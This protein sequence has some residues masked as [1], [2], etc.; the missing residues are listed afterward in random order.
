MK[1]YKILIFIL[2]V[3]ALLGAGWVVFPEE[4][5]E[6]PGTTLRFASLSEAMT[7]LNEEKV[8]VDNVLS[9]LEQSFQLL[10]GSVQDS[11]NFYKTYMESN[12]NRIWLPEGDYSYFDNIFSLLENA[13][14]IGKTYRIMHYGDSQIEMDHITG[15]FRE[16][17]QNLFGGSGPGMIPAQQNVPGVS[18]LQYA[19]GNIN[20]YAIYADSTSFRSSHNRYGVMCYYSKCSGSAYITFRPTKHS[21]SQ[22]GVKNFHKVNVLIGN[23]SAGFSATLKCDGFEAQKKTCEEAVEGMTMLSWEFPDNIKKGTLSFTGTAEIYAITL[24]GD[25]GVAVDNDGMRGCGGTIFSMINSEQ[26]R[27]SYQMLDTKLIMLQFGGNAMP[28]IYNDKGISTYL[29]KIEKQLDYFAK[30]APQAKLLFIG[31][32]DMGKSVNGKLQTWPRLEALNDSLKTTCLE[33]G[34][35]YWDLFQV[36]GGTNSMAQWVKHNP[37]YAAPDYIHFSQKGA[38]IIGDALATAFETYYKFYCLRKTLPEEILNYYFDNG[39]KSGEPD[40]ESSETGE[41]AVE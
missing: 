12:P 32:S 23:S 5:I 24:D 21:Y 14:R 40:A 28:S 4:G 18:V 29:R 2:A 25:G 20:R 33:R 8:D 7:E 36:M 31:P 39:D 30:V 38:D 19:S 37:P 9:E 16:R 34:V 13:Q 1:A 3:F 22:E 10:P 11:L 6:V 35:A 17:M 27:R 41:E 26:L 15:M